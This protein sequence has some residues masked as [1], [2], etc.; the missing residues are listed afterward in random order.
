MHPFPD[1]LL[2]GILRVFLT[3]GRDV[4]HVLPDPEGWR[5]T[6]RPQ[7]PHWPVHAI[8]RGLPSPEAAVARILAHSG[9]HGDLASL[10]GAR[11]VDGGS[12]LTFWHDG[13]DL[14]LALLE[15][16]RPWGMI[17]RARLR[18]RRRVRVVFLRADSDGRDA[19]VAGISQEDDGWR[20][21]RPGKGDLGPWPGPERAFDALAKALA[22]ETGSAHARLALRAASAR[23][24][25]D[26]AQA[27]A[28]EANP[29][30]AGAAPPQAD[31]RPATFR[32]TRGDDA[33][34]GILTGIPGRWTA[35]AETPW[36]TAATPVPRTFAHIP[37]AIAH[38]LTDPRLA[39][40]ARRHGARHLHGRLCL[41][42]G[43]SER[44]GAVLRPRLAARR[45]G[46]RRQGQI[47]ALAWRS[48]AQSHRPP[49]AAVIA[50]PK[51]RLR[52]CRDL[53]D[54]GRLLK[55]GAAAAE[56][57]AEVAGSDTRHA[58]LDLARLANETGEA[59]WRQAEALRT[60]CSLETP[61]WIDP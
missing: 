53:H 36:H 5:A 61:E 30:A 47:V 41:P 45:L 37:D 32:L 1:V 21:H 11:K 20:L 52:F 43:A 19:I 24:P 56:A 55:T 4:G 33:A 26:L 51:G 22:R 9:L 7:E 28:S 50:D 8:E 6:L 14:R 44:I 35:T 3:D 10:P 48:D 54:R 49:D 12:A 60:A 2:S 27:L 39:F 40:D 42:L 38:L 23:W 13:G 18:T 29:A 25:E 46:L 15:R 31:L 57:L 34:I 58:A 59:W 16:S 17:I